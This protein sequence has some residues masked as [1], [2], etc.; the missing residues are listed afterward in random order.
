MGLKAS[1]FIVLSLIA[2]QVDAFTVDKSVTDTA[3]TLSIATINGLTLNQ[4]ARIEP[5]NLA[6]CTAEDQLR[7]DRFL[8]LVSNKSKRT[9]L[10]EVTRVENGIVLDF[11]VDASKSNRELYP[12]IAYQIASAQPC[13]SESDSQLPVVSVF[14]AVS[15]GELLSMADKYMPLMQVKANSQSNAG[16][17]SASKWF[18]S[19]VNDESGMPAAVTF[20]QPD[21]QQ[22]TLLEVH[23]SG[24]NVELSMAVNDFLGNNSQNA[25]LRFDQEKFKPIRLGLTENSRGFVFTQVEEILPRL[26][27][28]SELSLRYTNYNGATKTLVYPLAELDEK[29]KSYP[30]FC[31]AE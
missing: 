23:C 19:L 10:L 16:E 13:S 2:T 22:H 15:Q 20:S 26:R 12:Y 24:L 30:A 27:Q 5:S 3:T 11:T 6:I 1:G 17:K 21:S 4:S 18:T 25:L 29:L 8:P 7:V 31:G 14:G 9:G 28:T